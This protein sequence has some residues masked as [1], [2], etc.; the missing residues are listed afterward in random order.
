MIYDVVRQQCTGTQLPDL[1]LSLGS[2]LRGVV[3]HVR[4][5]VLKS[6][7]SRVIDTLSTKLT[8]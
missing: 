4:R 7:D 3:V 8:L 5:M 6:S 2:G 1:A